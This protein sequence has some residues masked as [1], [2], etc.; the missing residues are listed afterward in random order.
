MVI[1]VV[2]MWGAGGDTALK[3]LGRHGQVVTY[4]IIFS[5]PTQYQD[6][7]GGYYQSTVSTVVVVFATVEQALSAVGAF[8]STQYAAKLLNC[9]PHQ[10]AV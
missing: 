5:E 8:S 4:Q 9:G 10:Q 2:D 7:N 3:A 1:Y 6:R